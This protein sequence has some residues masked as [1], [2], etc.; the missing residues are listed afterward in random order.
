M[1]QPSEVKTASPSRPGSTSISS[2]RPPSSGPSSGISS[3]PRGSISARSAP[4]SRASAS[5]ATARATIAS[6]AAASPIAS[7]P[8]VEGSSRSSARQHREGDGEQPD[9]RER[10]APDAAARAEARTRRPAAPRH[11]HRGLCEREHTAQCGGGP[12]GGL[13]ARGDPDPED[14]LR[15]DQPGPHRQ[16]GAAGDPVGAQGRARAGAVGELERRGPEQ[17]RA[18]DQRDDDRQHAAAEASR[19]RAPARSVGV[20]GPVAVA[21]DR[22][23]RAD[24]REVGPHVGDVAVADGGDL[25]GGERRPGPREDLLDGLRVGPARRARA[26]MFASAAS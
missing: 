3:A 2:V 24:A 19:G 10:A 7:Q 14:G 18:E 6:S 15:G 5:T 26:P 8:S 9:A 12:R 17:Q 1:P 4:S 22:Q 23:E 16:G 25:G 21:A 20:R 13:D 11:Q